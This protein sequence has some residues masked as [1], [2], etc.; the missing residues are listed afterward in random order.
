MTNLVI[1][2][3]IVVT[4]MQTDTVFLVNRKTDPFPLSYTNQRVECCVLEITDLGTPD[5]KYL[6]SVQKARNECTGTLT[7]HSRFAVFDKTTAKK[8]P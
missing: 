4:N 8:G 2:A 6:F 1:L 5:G 7:T 3:A